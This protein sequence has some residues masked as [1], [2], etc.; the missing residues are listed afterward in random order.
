[1]ALARSLFGVGFLATSLAASCLAQG[2]PTAP[3]L[4]GAL[5][6]FHSTG[7]GG[8]ISGFCNAAA[9]WL[10]DGN[11]VCY[12][13]TKSPKEKEKYLYFM[14]IK[15]GAAQPGGGVRME[16]E[17]KGTENVKDDRWELELLDKAR[18]VKI[19]YRFKTD[20][21]TN[22]ILSE[23]S[24]VIGDL[25]LKP[26]DPRVVL[27]DL[28]GEKPSYKA[29]KVALPD[30]VPELADFEAKRADAESRARVLSQAIRDL[31]KKSP[32]VKEFLATKSK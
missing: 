20:A 7:A 26:E 10:P 12:A 29:V 23:E 27:V 3:V 32:E 13:I 17:A 18:R 28:T 4:T 5:G 9:Q 11:A 24:L 25:K 14:V 19:S 31:E 6:S 22:A 8:E 15:T 16:G 1:M 2:K 30:A 21:K